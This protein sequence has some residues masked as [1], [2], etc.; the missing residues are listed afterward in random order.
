M[1]TQ[2]LGAPAPS[3]VEAEFADLVYGDADLLRAEYEALIASSWDTLPPHEPGTRPRR[4]GPAP[5]NGR[6]CN[7]TRRQ[8]ATAGHTPP[9]SAR[10]RGPP[11]H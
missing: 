2:T 1:S 3:T 11:D 5:G 10:Q 6:R 9:V 8:P 4:P 7:P